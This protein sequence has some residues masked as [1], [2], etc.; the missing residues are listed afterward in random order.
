MSLGD[1]G[2]FSC[3]I[4]LIR[5]RDGDMVQGVI[6]GRKSLQNCANEVLESMWTWIGL[7]NQNPEVGKNA[8]MLIGT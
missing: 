4:P 3:L 2:F 6:P 7:Q 5:A 1:F 8:T